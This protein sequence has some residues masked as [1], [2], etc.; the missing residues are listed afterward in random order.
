MR[1]AV[2][3]LLAGIGVCVLIVLGAILWLLGIP[4]P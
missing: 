2:D 4:I 3:Q 1:R